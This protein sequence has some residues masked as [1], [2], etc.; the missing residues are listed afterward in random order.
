[1]AH[2]TGAA[3]SAD[4]RRS[5]RA[6]RL[7]NLA[8]ILAVVLAVIGPWPSFN[9][10]FEGSA[11]Q[12]KTLAALAQA[13]IFKA[14]QGPVRA[15][16]AEADLAPPA[17]LPLAGF[18]ARSPKEYESV[19]S[20]CLARAL[21]VERQGTIVTI[22]TADLLLVNREL[23][24][25]VL[26]RCGLADQPHLLYF[27]ASHTHSG[28]G[29]W[30]SMW[31][32]RLV[33]GEYNASYFDDLAARLAQ[34]VSESRKKLEPVELASVAVPAGQW[35]V[36]RVEEALPV[37]PLLWAI[38]LRKAGSVGAPLAILCGYSAHATLLGSSSRQLSCDYPGVLI[39]KLKEA[40]SASTVLFAAASVGDCSARRP[41][42]VQGGRSFE[43]YGMALVDPLAKALSSARYQSGA[44]MS[45][46]RWPIEMETPRVHLGA[47]LQM[48]PA[49]TFWLGDS[50]TY[51]HFL[52]LGETW[53]VGMPCDFPG[54]LT[55]RMRDRFAGDPPILV[56]S[57]NGDY[58]GYFTSRE[59]FIRK[60]GYETRE[61]NF[62]GASAGDYLTDLAVRGLIRLGAPENQSNPMR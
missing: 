10:T 33:A 56:T 12:R 13:P 3:L 18:G 30:G 52:G 6:R 50:R 9:A 41:E 53:L 22:L 45:V 62:F 8:I 27:T 60:A 54:H 40:T 15:G 16:V 26:K 61:M 46:M 25:A 38:A 29:G 17:G 35:L 7:R 11:Y 14:G 24:Q 42:R 47:W 1:M 55:L 36:N 28:P 31:I 39:R 19:E 58:K 49:S 44:S 34:A 59:V 5:R 4:A 21:S 51:I 37:D 48:S 32:E 20:P 43:T 2:E 23:S 57:F